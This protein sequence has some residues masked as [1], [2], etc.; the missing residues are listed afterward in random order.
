M[1]I[2]LS[3]NKVAIVSAEDAD[4]DKLNWYAKESDGNWYAAHTINATGKTVRMHK[5]IAGRMGLTGIVDHKNRNGLDNRRSNLRVATTQQNT[6]NKASHKGSLSQY[7]GVDYDKQAKKWRARI[8][9]R[10]Q[11]I[12][13]GNFDTEP[14]A[15]VAYDKCAVH[16]H[17]EFAYLNFPEMYAQAQ[18]D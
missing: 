3:R 1:D 10:G 6:Q 15:A 14:E 7:K 8:N 13:L 11:S 9:G 18:T 4:L 2:R 12:F 16:A 5:V 17:G